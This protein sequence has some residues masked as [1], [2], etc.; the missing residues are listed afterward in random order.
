MPRYYYRR[1]WKPRWRKRYRRFWSWGVRAP[2]R[3]RRRRKRRV[4]RKLPFLN[5]KQW[6]PPHINKMTIKG[7]FCLMQV[8]K[9]R[10]NHDYNQYE[11]SVP[12]EGLPNGGGFSILRFTLQALFEQH[13]KAHNVWT[14]SNT[15]MPLF[16][17]TGCDIKVYRPENIDLVIK[18]QTCYPM[19]SSKLLFTGTQPSLM[20]M[21]KGSKLIRCRKSVPNAKPYKKYKLKVP[22]QMMNKWY[23]QHTECNTGLLLIQAASASFDNYYTSSE[24]ESSTI[25]LRSLNTRIF[26]NL[27]FS[28]Y[29]TYGY[30]PNS[31]YSLWATNGSDRLD[32]LIWLGNTKKYQKGKMIKEVVT[33]IQ[34]NNTAWK[35]A[36]QTYMQKEENWGNPFYQDHIHHTSTLVRGTLPP[37]QQLGTSSTYKPSTTYTEA[38]MQK[39]TE[40]LFITVRYNPF[41]DKGYDNNIYILPNYTSNEDNLDPLPDI[42]LQNPGFPNWL[43]CFGFQDYLIKLGKKSKINE[44][45][46]MIWKSKYFDP[47]L[48]YY[49]FVDHWFLHGDSE[50]LEGRT[51]WD[52]V[53][54]YPQVQH[55]QGELNVLAL[56]GP[57]APKLGKTK[58]AEAKIE[59]RFYFKV[60]GCGAP[61][62]K[63]ANPQT[64]PTYATPTNILDQHSLQSPEEPIETFLY[65]FDWRRHQIT[66]TAAKR[67]SQD[68][69]I[70]KYLFTDAETTGTAV[71]LHQT[72][73]KDL[74]ST[75]EE[76]TQKETLFQQLLDNKLKQQQL[77]QRI[78]QLMTQIHEL[79]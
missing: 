7:L 8:H 49:I 5:L 21:T 42:D 10:Y 43:S 57:G 37:L 28:T 9:T 15:N 58:L 23:F 60:G 76:E 50:E 14:K 16:R 62:E 19:S 31:N 18:F 73:E 1:R 51:G 79:E 27:N 61:V 34:D 38:Q 74:L 65:Q 77:R 11:T 44:H 4:R 75:E 2:F 47:F 22:S 64:Q 55:Q 71:P 67:I 30:M 35:Q 45:W 72:H 54:W 70:G 3:R 12:K 13:E 53:N 52:S 24:S 41:K 17:Y 56:C 59:Y 36:L 20:M 68:Y 46:V 66:E 26:K 6:Q 25:T 69:S 48:P 40:D 78:K 32:E 29:P 39:V 63:V 33:N